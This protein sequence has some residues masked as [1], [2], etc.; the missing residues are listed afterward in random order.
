MVIIKSHIVPE[1]LEAVRLYDYAQ[2]IFTTIPSRKGIKKA[3]SRGEIIVDGEQATT[4]LW[5]KGGEKIELLESNVNTPKAYQLKLEVVF[6]D[7]FFAVINKPAGISVS[8]NQFRTIQNALIGS[9]K[10]SK[11]EDALRWPKPVHRLDAPTSGLL[12]VAKTA[13]AL[14]KLGQMFEN[15]EIQKKYNAIVIGKIPERGTIDFEIEGLSSFTDYKLNRVVPSLRNQH[16][17]L[18]DLYPKTGRTHQLRIHLS[19]LGFPILGDKRYGKAG[20]ILEGKGLFLSALELQLNHP[21][22]NEQLTIKAEIPHKFSALL[23]REN[24]RF[25][26]YNP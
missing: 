1:G 12:L 19:K 9:I 13:T 26:K 4:G 6:E 11:E 21:I 10:L 2:L 20:E 3:I 15:K 14:M 5:L 23:E 16:L 24:R 7:E 25:K 22:T 17:S 8:G 18:V